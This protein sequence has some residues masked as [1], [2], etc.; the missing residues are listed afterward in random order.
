MEATRASWIERKRED[1]GEHCAVSGFC[2]ADYTRDMEAVWVPVNEEA[3]RAIAALAG[4][5]RS[6]QERRVRPVVPAPAS[7]RTGLV[8][9]LVALNILATAGVPIVRVGYARTSREAADA[10]ADPGSPVV[11]KVLSADIL[12][13]SDIGGV[14]LGVVD[15]AAA[16]TALEEILSASRTAQPNAA[17]DGCLIIPMV[18][19]GVETILGVQRHPVFGPSVIFGLGG[20]IVEALKDGP[21]APPPS[22][23]RKRG[24]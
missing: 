20:I 15:R 16:E 23:D 24:P 17:I 5:A 6:F 9:E 1:P 4:F 2:T 7:L 11:L 22:T 8:N 3:M 10:A 13:K 18:T 14:R 12:H 21:S 19:G